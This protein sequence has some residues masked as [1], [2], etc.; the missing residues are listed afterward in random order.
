MWIPEFQKKQEL[1]I[2]F[3]PGTIIYIIKDLFIKGLFV[4]VYMS[5]V[6]VCQSRLTPWQSRVGW[7][8]YLELNS[9]AAAI[10]RSVKNKVNLVRLDPFAVHLKLL[11]H[12]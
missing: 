6:C 12:C 3:Q 11:Q 2:K 5:C 4:S 7:Q 10:W 8:D 9:W 1:G